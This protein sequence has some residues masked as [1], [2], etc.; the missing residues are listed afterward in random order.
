[1]TDRAA[2]AEAKRR[3]GRLAMVQPPR[4][5]G[6]E[7]MVGAVIGPRAFPLFGVEGLG[8]S[9]E[10]AFTAADVEAERRAKARS[11]AQA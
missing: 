9:W 7:Y 2:L 11:E 8:A 3:W 1:M 4:R 5:A 10:D 6:G